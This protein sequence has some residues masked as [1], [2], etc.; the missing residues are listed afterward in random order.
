MLQLGPLA[1]P[2]RAKGPFSDAIAFVI[3][4]GNYEEY[5]EIREWAARTAGAAAGAGAAA[6]TGAVEKSVVYGSTELLTGPEFLAQ[7]A[8]LG[9]KSAH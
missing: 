9:R 6:A 5:Q 1:P 4:G 8:E 7:L 2:R 3:G